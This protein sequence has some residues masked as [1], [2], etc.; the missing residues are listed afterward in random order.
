MEKRGDQT[1]GSWGGGS[2]Q[3]CRRAE[4][5][6]GQGRSRQKCRSSHDPGGSRWSADRGPAR[7]PESTPTSAPWS[8]QA[9]MASA[10]GAASRHGG[11]SWPCSWWCRGPV[12]P[13]PALRISPRVWACVARPWPPAL[14]QPRSTATLSHHLDDGISTFAFEKYIYILLM[15]R[16]LY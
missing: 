11:R 13:Y 9:A 6:R 10:R 5:G 3:Q 15:Y 14:Q 12:L 8:E 7:T 1:K 2:G 16:K 4:T